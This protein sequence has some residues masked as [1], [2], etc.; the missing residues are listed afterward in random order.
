MTSASGVA[1]TPDDM[2]QRLNLALRLLAEIKAE[3][4][5]DEQRGGFTFGS[6][7]G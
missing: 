2:E 6:L 4:Q 3:G 5:P 1:D 7:G